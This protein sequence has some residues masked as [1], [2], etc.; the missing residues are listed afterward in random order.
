[1]NYMRV[2]SF[3]PARL[4]DVQGPAIVLPGLDTRASAFLV[5]EADPAIVCFITGDYVGSA[6]EKATAKNW[7]GLAVEGVRFEVD[8][9]SKFKPAYVDQPVGSII[10]VSGGLEVIVMM[11][12]LHGFDEAQRVALSDGLRSTADDMEVGFTR[13]R[14]MLGHGTDAQEIFKFEATKTANF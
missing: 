5:T 10:R 3:R 13:W 6:F 4:P 2:E 8:E 9:S 1:M 11:K 14:A 12:G 7:S